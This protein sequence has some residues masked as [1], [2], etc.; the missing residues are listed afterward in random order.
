MRGPKPR[1]IPLDVIRNARHRASQS[2]RAAA[3][4]RPRSTGSRGIGRGFR[5][6]PR[7]GLV[8]QAAM[9]DTMR[10]RGTGRGSA[11]TALGIGKCGANRFIFP[12]DHEEL[13]AVCVQMHRLS[14]GSRGTGGGFAGHGVAAARCLDLRIIAAGQDVDSPPAVFGELPR[15]D[16]YLA[17]AR[18]VPRESA[19]NTSRVRDQFLAIRM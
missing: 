13:V 7:D 12:P 5:N 1:P 8:R 17:K 19:T 14:T 11:R 15:C 18:P 2:Q 16:Q 9:P 3:P 6:G 4:C 10:S